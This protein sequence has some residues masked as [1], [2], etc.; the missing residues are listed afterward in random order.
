MRHGLAWTV[1]GIAA[2]G[3]DHAPLLT[4]ERDRSCVLTLVNDTAFHHPIHLHGHAFRVISRDG[5]PTR[6]REWQDTV[7]IAPRETV[8]VAFV[9]DNP[10]KWMIHCHA[11]EHQAGGM[12][13]VIRVA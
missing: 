4:L 11:L 2:S 13:G 7:L 6:H 8:E 5:R 10:G 1:N 3:H 9:A 12:S